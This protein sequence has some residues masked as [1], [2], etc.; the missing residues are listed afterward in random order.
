MPYSLSRDEQS[1]LWRIAIRY[2][3]FNIEWPSGMTILILSGEQFLPV[4]RAERAQMSR[5]A[6]IPFVV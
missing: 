6:L 5:A 1:K 3:A 2:F 4:D